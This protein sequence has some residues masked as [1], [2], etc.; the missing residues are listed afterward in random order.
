MLTL[1]TIVYPFVFYNIILN[2]LT[3]LTKM[4]T[5]PQGILVDVFHCYLTL[6]SKCVD[7]VDRKTPKIIYAYTRVKNT[8]L[9][10]FYNFPARIY[11]RIIVCHT[12]NTSTH[13]NKTH[14]NQ[15]DK[16]PNV[17]TL[18]KNHAN[19]NSIYIK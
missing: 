12:V 2:V 13:C 7:M 5:L 9:K 8:L 10:T 18:T 1:V 14:T 6:I 4:L 15:L 11:E 16:I 17:L 3:W 19:T